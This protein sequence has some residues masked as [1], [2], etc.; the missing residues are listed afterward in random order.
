M[1]LGIAEHHQRLGQRGVVLMGIE[2]RIAR[3]FISML[4][5]HDTRRLTFAAALSGDFSMTSRNICS[6]V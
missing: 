5:H 1:N 4:L 3:F 6:A 2:R